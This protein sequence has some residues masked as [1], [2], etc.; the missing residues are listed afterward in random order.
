MSEL[1]RNF[2][3]IRKKYFL[4]AVIAGAVLGVC[5]GVGLTCALAV[6][7]KRCA[8][9]LHWAIYIPVCL[10]LSAAL[11][12]AFYFVLKPDDVKIAKKLDKDFSLNQ[13]VQAMV[14]NSAAT[15]A[16][17]QLQREQADEALGEVAKKRVDLKW[18]LK[19]AFVPVLAIAMLFV[20]IFVPARK[21]AEKDPVVNLT[22]AQ[23][24]ALSNLITEVKG[25]SLQED[26]KGATVAVLENLL[27]GLKEE[28]PQSVVRAAVIS[29]VNLIDTVV[30]TSNSYLKIFKA[31]NADTQLKS[32]SVA[33]AKGVIYYRSGGTKLTN[34]QIVN[35]QELAAESGITSAINK[36]RDAFL[37]GYTEEGG[38]APISVKDA[39]K[40]LKSFSESLETAL[41]AE[42]LSAYFAAE[43][44]G[45]VETEDEYYGRVAAFAQ[46]LK[47]LSAADGITN[48]V[49]Y[50][51]GISSCCNRFIADGAR[52]LCVQSYACMMDEYIRTTLSKIFNIPA[53]AFG[54][55][56]ALPQ[57]AQLVDEVEG[58]KPNENPADWVPGGGPTYGS[59]DMVLNVDTG[60]PEAY[61]NLLDKY[62]KRVDEYVRGGLCADE[63][64]A[65]INKYFRILFAGPVDGGDGE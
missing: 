30:A 5:G 9:N 48:P 20:G 11:A 29:S 49:T 37:G 61:G 50:Y 28:Q 17:S 24:A 19:F 54:A 27:D 13:K 14:E 65:Y 3:T 51:D 26:T 16:M 43:E 8:V 52:A 36:W 56:P 4:V 22:S 7:L 39:S 25:S 60:L 31:L 18:L 64:A 57:D 58:E 40:K 21:G 23:S 63:L 44:G 10:A 38:V 55:N 6:V 33:T 15:D 45:E 59:D 2:Q 41:K 47:D 34:M 1:S 42:A 35:A 62:K 53:S 32:L 46:S 12:A